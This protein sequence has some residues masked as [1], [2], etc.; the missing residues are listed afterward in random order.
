MLL[1]YRFGILPLAVSIALLASVVVP[2]IWLSTT[3]PK[4]SAVLNSGE[5]VPDGR[6]SYDISL[7]RFAKW[8]YVVRAGWPYVVPGSHL[9]PSDVSL[10]EAGQPLGLLAESQSGSGGYEVSN[11][12][13]RFS[14]SD[15]SD[16]R[17]NGRT[18]AVTL[19][20]RLD[21]NLETLGIV[22]L[23]IW[24][25][26]S[27]HRR[28]LT[29]DA[30]ATLAYALP[31]AAS[32]IAFSVSLL[33]RPMPVI[34]SPDS[35]SYLSPALA[36]MSG[37]FIGVATFGRIA[38]CALIVAT[39]LFTTLHGLPVVQLFMSLIAV[40]A[41]AWVLFLGLRAT[42]ASMRQ[43]LVE[44]RLLALSLA[45]FF[46]VTTI[47]SNNAFVFNIY[48]VLTEAPHLPLAAVALLL[49][50]ATWL[51][52][53]AKARVP[54]AVGAVVLTYFST[55]VRPVTLITLCL[56]GVSLLVVLWK[57]RR[58]LYTR[59]N[60]SALIIGSILMATGYA[61]DKVTAG[62]LGYLFGPQTLFCFHIPIV[63][64]EVGENTP[65]RAELSKL[66]RNVLI[67][68][69]GGY[70]T[71]G[72]NADDNCF[73]DES[74]NLAFQRAADSEGMPRSQWLMRAFLAGVVHQPLAYARTVGDQLGAYFRRPFLD[75]PQTDVV[76]Q[77]GIDRDWD[78]L[79]PYASIIG[80]ERDDFAV[81]VTNW[82]P[83]D[84]PALIDYVRYQLIAKSTRYFGVVI[85]SAMALALFCL[86][87]AP[88]PGRKD[89]EI[90]V[91][92]VGS[93]LFSWILLVAMSHSFDI[94]RYGMALVPLALL[95]FVVSLVYV[96]YA[97]SVRLPALVRAKIRI[98]AK[99]KSG[100]EISA[101]DV[102]KGGTGW[103]DIKPQEP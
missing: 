69:P 67:R 1:L 51:V 28:R 54:L 41:I 79:K 43:S 46:F 56:A 52:R 81:R 85:S 34:Y 24:S 45:G 62:P 33:V 99:G 36:M 78:R 71:V 93:F 49:F 50:T 83:Q 76:S 65:E 95:W 39:L 6:H 94:L 88:A 96:I 25:V 58:T 97:F 72:Y 32:L 100:A 10:S 40:I 7:S 86:F 66:L 16:P 17:T 18:Y 8:P 103:P 91:L 42:T 90:V 64:P 12:E 26:W 68:P 11:G 57:D 22:A 53:S 2:V 98:H 48:N 77:M 80:M 31:I 61:A 102:P 87:V 74:V 20:T 73:N 63:L 19:Q 92:C 14:P 29:A 30:K 27:A 60:M 35:I 5:I 23:L 9:F 55:L 75:L 84:F 38:Y 47:L 15:D 4:V 70:P 37:H 3:A 13:L 101:L 82:V 44:L 89:S 59:A 21:P